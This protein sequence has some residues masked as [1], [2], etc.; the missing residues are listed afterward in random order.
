MKNKTLIISRGLEN[1]LNPMKN[2]LNNLNLIKILNKPDHVIHQAPSP[3]APVS[4]AKRPMFLALV[5]ARI[6]EFG[7]G[8]PGW[9]EGRRV[10][11]K[12]GVAGITV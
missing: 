7:L 10:H 8:M 3:G 6:G 4:K 5:S 12:E 11:Y 9:E 1:N 2:N